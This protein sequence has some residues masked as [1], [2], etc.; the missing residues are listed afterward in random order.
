MSKIAIALIEFIDKTFFGG[1]VPK[2]QTL[3]EDTLDLC[4]LI[5][6]GCSNTKVNQCFQSLS[7]KHKKPIEALYGYI[8]L[9]FFEVERYDYAN[10]YLLK[11]L[12]EGTF[13]KSDRTALEEKLVQ[14]VALQDYKRKCQ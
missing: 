3:R 2:R 6:K 11:A 10:K 14:S 8:G 4:L 7:A 9:E 5:V 13:S 1:E 12:T